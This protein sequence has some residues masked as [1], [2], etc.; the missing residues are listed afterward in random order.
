MHLLTSTAATCRQTTLRLATQLA[1]EFVDITADLDAFVAATG[2]HHGIVTVQ[3]THTTTGIVVNECEPLLLR[4]FENLLDDLAPR[5]RRYGHDDMSLRQ[6]V[7]ASEPA[8][9]HAHCR[10]LLLP[11]SVTLNVIDGRLTLGKWQRVFLVELDGPRERTVTLV[12]QGSP[13]L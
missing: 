13:A 11:V 2:V 6:G 4:D 12:L 9:G 8:N 3:T 1:T 5:Y 10:A 7:P